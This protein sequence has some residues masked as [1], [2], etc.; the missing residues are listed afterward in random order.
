MDLDLDGGLVGRVA[1]ASPVERTALA[2]LVRAGVISRRV[3]AAHVLLRHG[4]ALRAGERLGET[5]AELGDALRNVLTQFPVQAQGNP[6]PREELIMVSSVARTIE[7]LIRGV[8]AIPHAP[9]AGDPPKPRGL[10][11]RVLAFALTPGLLAQ[12][13]PRLTSSGQ[14]HGGD[15]GRLAK[16]LP[17]LEVHV[18]LWNRHGVLRREAALDVDLAR[19]LRVAE[20]PLWTLLGDLAGGSTTMP[21]ARELALLASSLPEGTTLDLGAALSAVSR[22]S[23]D[24]RWA[25]EWLG[26]GR[27]E[28]GLLDV[29]VRTA[30]AWLPPDVRR[31]LR[32]EPLAEDGRS[33]VQPDF[34]VLLHPSARLP[35]ALL[36]GFAAELHHLEKVA[37]LRL[38][39]KSVQTARALGATTRELVEV[40]ARISDRALPQTVQNAVEEWGAQVAAGDARDVVLLRLDGPAAS[41]ERAAA[42]LA[43]SLLVRLS[44]DRLL[45][46]RAPTPKELEKLRDAAVFVRNHAKATGSSDER[47]DPVLADDAAPDAEV[48]KDLFALPSPVGNPREADLRDLVLIDRVDALAQASRPLGN[49]MQERPR[50]R[51]E[52]ERTARQT[53]EAAWAHRPDWLRDLEEIRASDDFIRAYLRDRITVLAILSQARSPAI[54][55][56]RL[57]ELA[58]TD[59]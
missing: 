55:R 32:G 29:D 24:P 35:D 19:A 23:E 11:S 38:T 53:L 21:R 4:R 36:V 14:L 50:L 26:R 5:D 7:P 57:A 45:L 25:V 16:V 48:R 2:L 47:G 12:R 9:A 59:A 41:I 34:E 42:I 18:A 56:L 31:L 33:V 30:A 20:L 58:R 52:D 15:A 46:S 37:R 8:L 40:L 1:S 13:R 51:D 6:S 27:G 22:G 39:Q 3:L 44:E 10:T 54:L 28:Y 43:S 17:E 49:G